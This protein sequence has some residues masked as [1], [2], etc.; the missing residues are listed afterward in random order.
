MAATLELLDD[1]ELG[2][3]ELD[4]G[5]IDEGTL[6]LLGAILLDELL[7]ELL[8]ATLDGAT[9]EVMLLALLK[10]P[11]QL[12]IYTEPNS[13]GLLQPIGVVAKEVICES[14]APP[15]SSSSTDTSKPMRSPTAGVTPIVLQ[16]IDTSSVWP[17]AVA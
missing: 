11:E 17:L 10:L 9:L 8:G 6:L 13:D 12:V 16:G 15:L 1:T 7:R 4:D 3:T 2:A 5:A 14:R